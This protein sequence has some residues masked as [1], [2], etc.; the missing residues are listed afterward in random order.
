MNTKAIQHT[1]EGTMRTLGQIVRVVFDNEPPSNILTL[2]L[3]KPAKGITLVIKSAE[4]LRANDPH[5]QGQDGRLASLMAKLPAELPPGPISVE[6]Q[7][8]F[9]LGYYQTP[10]RP[11]Q[12]DVQGLRQAGE[13]LYGS[14]WQ[15]SLAQALELSDARR[16]REW[17]SG[18][19]RVPP[20]VWD[21]IKRLLEARSAQAMAVAGG[22]DIGDVQA[23]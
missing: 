2:L 22:L 20:G 11:V 9:W 13:A 5:R 4:G 21:D 16:V 15:T 23:S 8:P 14:T 7:G 19:R 6:M 1:T 3:S 10:K 12:R 17:L 18:D